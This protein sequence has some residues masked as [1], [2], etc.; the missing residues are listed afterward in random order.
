MTL[1][2]ISFLEGH[3]RNFYNYS[4]KKKK[5]LFSTIKRKE[6]TRHVG[7]RPRK[8]KWAWKQPSERGLTTT[9]MGLKESYPPA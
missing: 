9:A 1:I 3:K 8:E 6:P 7:A 4:K 2:A 5:K